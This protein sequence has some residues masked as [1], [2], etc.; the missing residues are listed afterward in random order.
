MNDLNLKLKEFSQAIRETKEY[1]AYQRA[2]KIYE[3]DQDA[4]QLLKDFQ[5]AQQNVNIY[6]Q[7]DF[8]GLEEQKKRYEDLLKEVRKNKTI[9]DWI[10]MQKDV[11]KL[12][13]FLATELSQDIDFKFIPLEKKGC[14]G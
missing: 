14:C 7:G 8:S 10:K 12:V 11:Q 6:Q 9:N 5:T 1:Q 13:G 3:K 4:Q 2:A